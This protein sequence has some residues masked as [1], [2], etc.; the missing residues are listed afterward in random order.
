[1]VTEPTWESMLLEDVEPPIEYK[2]AAP[3]RLP[4]ASGGSGVLIRTNKGT[5]KS[6]YHKSEGANKAVIWVS[7]AMGGYNGGGGLYPILADELTDDNISSLRLNYRKPSEFTDSVLDII[8]GVSFLREQGVE[9][10]ALVGHSFGG[11]VIVAAAP[12][13]DA[14]VTLICLASQSYG[15]Q[16]ADMI[17]PRSILLVHGEDDTRL[18]PHCSQFIFDKALEPKKLV[19]LPGAGHS[20]REARDELHPLMKQWILDNL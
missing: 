16:Y 15:G 7:G 2:G 8:A 10:I 12:L 4:E 11:A 3:W 13:C 1:M 14:V 17:E 5:I 20:L 18:G 6:L 19:L 9:R